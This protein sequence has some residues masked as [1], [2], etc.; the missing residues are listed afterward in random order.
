MMDALVPRF[1]RRSRRLVTAFRRWHNRRHETGE[2]PAEDR[3]ADWE[4]VEPTGPMDARTRRQLV[5]D[6]MSLD[7]TSLPEGARVVSYGCGALYPLSSAE[8]DGNADAMADDDGENVWFNRRVEIYF[9]TRPFGI[10]PEVPGVPEGESSTSAV[11]AGPGDALYPEWRLR[12]GRHHQILGPEREIT[13]LDELGQPLRG[14]KVRL[15][16]PEHDARELVSDDAGK[17]RVRVPPGCQFDLAIEDIHEGAP[18]DSLTTE[19]GHH[20]ASGADGPEADS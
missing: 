16:V 14:R 9:F 20:F 2:A 17:I 12:A 1:E 6:Y 11:L 15:L 5:L 4:S 8:S 18:G 10:L 3:P 19:S 13:L 7:G